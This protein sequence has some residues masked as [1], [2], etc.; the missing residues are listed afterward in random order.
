MKFSLFVRRYYLSS[1]TG[2]LSNHEDDGDKNIKK[3]SFSTND[4]SDNEC[5]IWKQVL[6]E[7]AQS[8]KSQISYCRLVVRRV[9]IGKRVEP[10]TE[11]VSKVDSIYFAGFK[12]A[13]AIDSSINISIFIQILC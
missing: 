10:P 6:N 2:S 3:E 4:E 9:L 11:K 12:Y 8:L 7:H 13:L 5:K 1:A